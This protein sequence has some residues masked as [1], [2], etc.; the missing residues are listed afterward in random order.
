M[1]LGSNGKHCGTTFVVLILLALSSFL[2]K[3]SAHQRSVR[4]H[5]A[6]QFRHRFQTVATSNERQKLAEYKT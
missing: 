4:L 2:H 6:L 1:K 3:G 5:E